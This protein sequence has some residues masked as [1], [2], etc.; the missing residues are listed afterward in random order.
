[1]PVRQNKERLMLVKF[2]KVLTWMRD[3]WLIIGITV[4]Y[5]LLIE[6]VL[7]IAFHY[8]DASSNDS[9]ISADTYQ[10]ADW[11]KKYYKEFNES[12]NSEWVSYVYWRREPYKGQYINIDSQGIRKTWSSNIGEGDKSIHPKIFMF[13]GSAM[14][15]T[16]SRDD[17]TIPSI[18]SKRLAKYGVNAQTVNFGESGYVSTQEVI[19]LIRELQKMN[20]PDLVIFYDGVNDT[21]SA[22]QQ[23]IAGI[24][25]NEF[26]RVKDFNSSKRIATTDLWSSFANNLSTIQFVKAV[27]RRLGTGSPSDNAAQHNTKHSLSKSSA[28]NGALA[29]DVLN[30]YEKNIEIVEYLAKRYSFKALFYW[31]PTIF[32]KQYRTKYEEE[33]RQRY[34]EMQLFF[35][36]T[37]GLLRQRDFSKDGEIEFHDLSMLFSNVS[38]P[39]FVDWA[40]LGETGNSYIAERLVLDT[41]SIMGG[42]LSAEQRAAPDRLS[43]PLQG[44]R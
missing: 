30:I 1:R 34:L 9:R 43:T 25:Q 44:D 40:H 10:N 31:Q 15:G 12:Y 5:I 42:R 14:W 17:F 33:K 21:Y 35:D 2:K 19:M 29:N 38:E 37:Y 7:S 4:A 3:L 13:G 32:E 41:I 16:G 18:F 39:L 8:R 27:F 6:I 20:I 23:Q 28:N 26:N 24:P 11:P 36:M 22:Y